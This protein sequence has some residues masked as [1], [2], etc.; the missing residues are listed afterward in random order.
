MKQDIMV[1]LILAADGACWRIDAFARWA[2]REIMR[3]ACPPQWLVNLSLAQSTDEI[4]SRLRL[5]MQ[6][7]GLDAPQDMNDLVYGFALEC[8]AQGVA[9]RG[10]AARLAEDIADPDGIC[11]LTI[12]DV[13][14]SGIPADV[15]EKLRQ[16][17]APYWAST[18][19]ADHPPM[20]AL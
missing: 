7:L 10:H 20:D 11:G 5:D 12:E 9:P 1:A 18:S 8:E 16:R 13:L 3:C 4:A 17:A 2:D 6:A 19:R 14:H 15:A